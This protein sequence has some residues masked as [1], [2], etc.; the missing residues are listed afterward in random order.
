M[1]ES[2]L[3]V[4]VSY[5]RLSEVHVALGYMSN[6]KMSGKL[7]SFIT[8]WTFQIQAAERTRKWCIHHQAD[9]TWTSYRLCSLPL[10]VR[11]MVLA[12]IALT[13]LLL[14]GEAYKQVLRLLKV[15]ELARIDSPFL[16]VVLWYLSEEKWYNGILEPIVEV[17]YLSLLISFLWVTW[18]EKST[19]E[20]LQCHFFMQYHINWKI[21][22]CVIL[23]VFEV[24]SCL[25]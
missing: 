4:G 24:V 15:S 25:F 16:P 10:G 1:L 14:W 12:I 7:M 22:S 2:R 8:C 17:V 6:N 18:K 9:S 19:I 3:L 11:Y 20:C 21:K 23:Y 13:I 5:I